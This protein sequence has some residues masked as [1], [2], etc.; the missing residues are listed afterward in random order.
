M[1]V[2]H[3]DLIQPQIRSQVVA[4]SKSSLPDNQFMGLSAQMAIYCEQCAIRQEARSQGMGRN[5]LFQSAGVTRCMTETAKCLPYSSCP[6]PK[7]RKRYLS[8]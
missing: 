1:T 3:S 4:F 2:I 8:D 5:D 7:V 6:L